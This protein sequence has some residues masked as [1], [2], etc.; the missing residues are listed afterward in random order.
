MGRGGGETR[1]RGKEPSIIE[2]QPISEA[3]GPRDQ[4]HQRHLP[5]QGPEGY[6]QRDQAVLA[7]RELPRSGH[8]G[9]ARLLAHLRWE[10]KE[11]DRDGEKRR[12]Q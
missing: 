5:L 10:A 8:Q 1:Q 4:G 7:D 12:R 3:G 9:G 6:L 11:G 2:E